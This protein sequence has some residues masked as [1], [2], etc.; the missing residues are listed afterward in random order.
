MNPIGPLMLK[1]ELVFLGFFFIKKK[2]STFARIGVL[3]PGIVIKHRGPMYEP[4]LLGARSRR[5]INVFFTHLLHEIKPLGL[6]KE[7]T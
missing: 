2:R 4:R 1:L 3:L 6:D 7:F 5:L